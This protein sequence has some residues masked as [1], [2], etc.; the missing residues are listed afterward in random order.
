MR[1]SEYIKKLQIAV[2]EHGDLEVVDSHGE[3]IG[4]PEFNDDDGTSVFVLADK[5]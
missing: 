4:T 2:A 5:S 1:A 3:T